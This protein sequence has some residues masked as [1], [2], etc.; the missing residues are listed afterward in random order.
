M[1]KF[2]IT[3]EELLVQEFT[4]T[5]KNAE[6]AVALAKEKYRD[7]EFILDFG[8]VQFKRLAVTDPYGASSEWSEF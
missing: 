4:L 3:I 6:E 8:E 7:G 5:A 1:K 2:N